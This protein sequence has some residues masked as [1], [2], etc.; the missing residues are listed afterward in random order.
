MAAATASSATASPSHVDRRPLVWVSGR[1]PESD[2]VRAD[3]R[4]ACPAHFDTGQIPFWYR[5]GTI[6]PV[7]TSE[8][9][10]PSPYCSKA[11][12]KFAFMASLQTSTARLRKAGF[13]CTLLTCALPITLRA[14]QTEIFG[15]VKDPSGAAI[16]SARVTIH[17]AHKLETGQTDSAGK[18]HFNLSDL[19]G[20]IEVVAH[21]FI[22]STQ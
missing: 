6:F 13:V 22:S 9:R 15:T 3:R 17:S 2:F 14:Q 11:G 20:T 12:W 8:V 7:G 19:T 5:E 21:G 16:V 10:A 1:V 18:F 4:A